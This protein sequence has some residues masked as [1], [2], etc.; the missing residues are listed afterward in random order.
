MDLYII[1]NFF[2]IPPKLLLGVYHPN[3][4]SKLLNDKD[5]SME[6]QKIETKK[7]FID[8][9][10]KKQLEQCDNYLSSN[11]KEIL[12]NLLCI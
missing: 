11:T 7:K 8:T 12:E 1:Q 2:P 10:N 6:I 4:S 9:H 5:C 3:F